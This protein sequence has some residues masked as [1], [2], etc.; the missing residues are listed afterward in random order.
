MCSWGFFSSF[1]FL[2]F[3]YLWLFSF[4]SINL[5]AIQ[6]NA[7]LYSSSALLVSWS[8]NTDTLQRGIMFWFRETQTF[9]RQYIEGSW[10]VVWLSPLQ[11]SD[12]KYLTTPLCCLSFCFKQY[13]QEWYCHSSSRLWLICT[14]FSIFCVLLHLRILTAAY[15]K[16]TLPNLF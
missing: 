10:A 5:S 2:A 14:I 12:G 1:A 13:F 3:W 15:W 8:W 4:F 6:T 16:V 9:L 7:L 11:V